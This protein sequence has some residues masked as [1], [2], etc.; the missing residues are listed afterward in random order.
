MNKCSRK[1]KQQVQ[2]DDLDFSH[3]TVLSYNFVLTKARTMYKNTIS[4]IRLKLEENMESD[5]SS[6]DSLDI[7]INARL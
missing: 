1:G 6:E 7:E 2:R 4:R 3:T 5:S